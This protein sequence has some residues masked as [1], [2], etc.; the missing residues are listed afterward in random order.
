MITSKQKKDYA[1][2]RGYRSWFEMVNDQEL[3]TLEAHRI[4]QMIENES[5]V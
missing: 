5:N 1:K 3:T 4:E 2:S